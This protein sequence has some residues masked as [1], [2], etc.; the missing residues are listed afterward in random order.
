[1]FDVAITQLSDRKA[2]DAALAEAG[3]EYKDNKQKEERNKRLSNLV[4]RDI[5]KLI[6]F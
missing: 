2:L 1:M 5:Y 3:D 6:L 4:V